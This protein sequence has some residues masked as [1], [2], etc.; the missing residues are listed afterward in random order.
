MCISKFDT[1]STDELD[2]SLDFTELDSAL[3]NDKCDYIE[4]DKCHNLNLNDYNLIIL[5]LNIQ[6]IENNMNSNNC[7]EIQK[8][9]IKSGYYPIM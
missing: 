6:R 5:Q 2:R 7:K 9:K 1:K 8:E 3:W 4:L